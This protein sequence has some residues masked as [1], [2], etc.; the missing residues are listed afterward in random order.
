V[1]ADRPLLTAARC[2]VSCK[3]RPMKCP[4]RWRQPGHRRTPGLAV[5]A[6]A[7]PV[8][9]A[10]PPWTRSSSAASPSCPGVMPRHSVDAP[11][12]PRCVASHGLRFRNRLMGG[13]TLREVCAAG[14]DES[15][16]S[17]SAY[18]APASLLLLHEGSEA[19]GVD[20]GRD[21]SASARRTRVAR[22][23]TRLRRVKPEVLRGPNGCLVAPAAVCIA[24]CPFIV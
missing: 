6:S 1:P 3:T 23:R 18:W 16:A 10:V 22:P 21:R 5:G 14:M 8:G 19:A 9:S 7:S 4:T 20:V 2:R 12:Q 11:T 15:Q 13:G 24:H 17:V